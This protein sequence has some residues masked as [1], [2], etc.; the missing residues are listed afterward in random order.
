MAAL[1][2]RPIVA[3]AFKR[4]RVTSG[5]SRSSDFLSLAP[6]PVVAIIHMAARDNLDAMFSIDSSPLL[7]SSQRGHTRM[8]C[9][10]LKGVPG[11]GK[12]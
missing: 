5:Q 12:L 3:N 8:D 2:I 1:D 6:R 7:P 4:L 9:G 11:L 10:K